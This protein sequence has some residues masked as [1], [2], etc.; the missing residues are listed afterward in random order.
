[1]AEVQ[2][3]LLCD[4]VI[5]DAQSGKAFLQGVFD[6]IWVRALPA[7]HRECAAYFRIRFE[8]QARHSFNLNIKAPSGLSQPTPESPIVLGPTNIAE[9][10]IKIEGLPLP[11]EGR[12]EIQFLIDGTKVA[13]YILDVINT[14]DQS[15]GSIH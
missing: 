10:A 1:M 7:T 8:D 6:R 14:G 9:G 5:R 4:S 11:D 3:F 12:Y 15:H 2:A 13:T